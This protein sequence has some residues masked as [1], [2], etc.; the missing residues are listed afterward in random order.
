M[1]SFLDEN[2]YLAVQKERKMEL[3]KIIVL[4]VIYALTMLVLVLSFANLPYKSEKGTVIKIITYVVTAIYIFLLY[5]TVGIKYKR[6]NKYYTMLTNLKT[7]TPIV[8][9]GSF[10]KTVED[11]ETRDFVDLKTIVLSVYVQRRQSFFDR[12]VYIPYE[13]EFPDFKVGQSIRVYTVE[14]ILVGYEFLDGETKAD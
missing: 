8:T 11:I 3:I 9:E 13:R 7:L 1:I 12:Y 5:V 6:I 14:N 10:V 4:A 2:E